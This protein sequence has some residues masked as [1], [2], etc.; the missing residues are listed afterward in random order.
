MKTKTKN[1]FSLKSAEKKKFSL[2]LKNNILI[3]KKRVY[4]DSILIYSNQKLRT[5]YRLGRAS[6]EYNTNLI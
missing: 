6:I 3:S 2:G 5:G 1:I 4:N